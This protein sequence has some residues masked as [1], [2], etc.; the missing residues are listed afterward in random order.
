VPGDEEHA[1]V[2]ELRE[3]GK[4]TIKPLAGPLEEGTW[5]IEGQIVSF[6]FPGTDADGDFTIEGDRLVVEG[7][8]FVCTKD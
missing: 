7:G 2:T 6:D 8:E 4:A 5:S 3:D 1:Q